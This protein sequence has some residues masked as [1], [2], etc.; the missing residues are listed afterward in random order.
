MEIATV[1]ILVGLI[2]IAGRVACL[3]VLMQNSNVQRLQYRTWVLLVAFINFAWIFYLLLGRA[4][5]K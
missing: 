4:K 1:I 5:K 2:D 3:A